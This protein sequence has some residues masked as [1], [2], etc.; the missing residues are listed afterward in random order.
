MYVNLEIRRH[1]F[2]Q[3]GDA[4]L[5]GLDDLERIGAGL[6]ADFENDGGRSIQPRE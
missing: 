2:L 5:D 1:C 6:L 4:C 3:F